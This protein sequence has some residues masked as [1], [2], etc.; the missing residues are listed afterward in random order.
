MTQQCN[1]KKEKGFMHSDTL[2]FSVLMEG[3]RIL[4]VVLLSPSH[5]HPFSSFLFLVGSLSQYTPSPTRG[6]A[7]HQFL[8]LSSV[9]FTGQRFS[10]GQSRGSEKAGLRG[11]E[12]AGHQGWL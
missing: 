8:F 6:Q 11:L 12:G 4:M 3:D 1:K 10:P 2:I 9:S 5:K 7:A